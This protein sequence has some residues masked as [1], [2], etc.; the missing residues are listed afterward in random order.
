MNQVNLGALLHDSLHPPDLS[1]L[2]YDNVAVRAEQLCRG[3]VR[4]ARALGRELIGS[5]ILVIGSGP[6]IVD[7]VEPKFFGQHNDVKS[8]YL[9]VI[10]IRFSP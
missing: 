9:D 5:D 3:E 10:P 1:C 8:I 4:I 7:I 6:Y 2:S